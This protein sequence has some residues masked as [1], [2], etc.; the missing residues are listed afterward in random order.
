MD[1]LA[2]M[3]AFARVVEAGTFSRAADT[4]GMPKPTVTKLIQMLEAHVRTR[5]LNRTTRRVTVTPDG[6]AYY[7]RAI[8]IINE[9]DELDGSLSTSQ[10]SP[11][12]R[13]RIDVSA[14]VATELLIPAMAA[15]HARYPDIQLDIGASDRP[16]DLLGENVDCVIR[17]GAIADPSLIA[18]RIATMQFVTCATPAYIARYGMPTHPSE[19]EQTHHVVGYFLANSNRALP[20]EYR[21]GEEEI[22]VNPRYIMSTNESAVTIAGG[23]AGLGV[24]LT[25]RFAVEAHL[26]SGALREVLPDW[27]MDPLPIHI[28]YPPN[29]HVSNKL[30]VFIEW[31]ASLFNGPGFGR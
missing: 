30:R 20:L 6:A 19:L 17:V 29:R 22:T 8:Q 11:K 23:L 25:A 2:A 13:L 26:A 12:G 9:L 15:F 21:R 4:L 31:A 1:Q 18:R 3:R 28:V 14:I 10:S 5:L 16:A 24:V 7:E 27:V